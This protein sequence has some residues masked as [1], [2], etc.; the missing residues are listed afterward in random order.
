[1]RLYVVS[2]V[3]HEKV[4]GAM[5]DREHNQQLVDGPQSLEASVRSSS[6]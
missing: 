2:K 4:E 3:R 1:M 5:G 6:P